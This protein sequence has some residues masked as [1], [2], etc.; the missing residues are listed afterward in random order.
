MNPG[1][2]AG[3]GYEIV[4]PDLYSDGGVRRHLVATIRALSTGKGEALVDIE[5]SRQWLLA[6]PETTEA[7]GI[8]GFCMGGGFALLTC[9]RDRYAVASVNYGTVPEDVG[10]ACPAVG[11]YGARDL[12]NRGAAQMNRPEF[13]RGSQV[14]SRRVP[15]RGD[16]DGRCPRA[17]RAGSCR[18]RREVA[19]D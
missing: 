1:R 10:H 12:Q 18:S 11:S 6:Q 15:M 2:I 4:V 19:G 7:V 13:T 9:D 5:T 14:P 8:V 16:C 3:W 17:R